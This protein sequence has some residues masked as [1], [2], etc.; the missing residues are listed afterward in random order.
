[1]KTLVN[2][3]LHPKDHLR[4]T[5]PRINDVEVL[6][7]QRAPYGEGVM[8]GIMKADVEYMNYVQCD[9]DGYHSEEAISTLVEI[10]THID[11]NYPLMVKPY[12]TNIGFQSNIYNLMYNLRKHNSIRDITGGLFGITN[13]ALK[14]LYE[15][16]PSNFTI[17]VAIQILLM[18]YQ[19][20]ILRVWAK[21]KKHVSQT[22]K[23]SDVTNP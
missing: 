16:Q 15:P 19:I 2:F 10:M 22:K 3:M 9:S 20:P 4:V 23:L 7:N 8:H 14:L 6:I 21:P 12:R 11:Y 1:M 5:A 13:S 18:R 17:I